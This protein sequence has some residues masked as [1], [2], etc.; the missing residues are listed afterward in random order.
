M[1]CSCWSVV[2][3]V[4]G[5]LVADSVEALFDASG[6]TPGERAQTQ[7][8]ITRF[9]SATDFDVNGFPITTDT[10]TAYSGGTVSDLQVNVEITVDGEISS[11]GDSVLANLITY[12]EIV[13]PTTTLDF[14]LSNFD[15]ISVQSVF[16]VTVS[17]DSDFL[18]QVTIDA[19]DANR[20]DVTQTG[21]TLNIGL[22]PASGNDN[23]QTIEAVVTM[24]ALTAINTQGV[25]DTTLNDFSQPQLR[26]DLS[27]V[28]RLY[29][30][31][32][33]IGALTANVIGVSQ[34]DLGDARP[35]NTANI[36]IA[37]VSTATLNMNIGSTLSGSVTGVSS[38]NYYGTNVVQ[39]LT[40]GAGSSLN[41]LG[42]TRP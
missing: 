24:P 31:S 3:V 23:I 36:D 33:S 38:L 4:S 29:S 1:G 35:L 41:R 16:K 40:I 14:N 22:L 32:I 42:E 20:V 6:G 37:G 13:S 39:N 11:S 28:S 25:I 34:L 18:V 26:I 8:V 17:Q 27:G 19:D 9:A 2:S 5:I 30:D 15:E 12:G 10:S 7:G 21:D